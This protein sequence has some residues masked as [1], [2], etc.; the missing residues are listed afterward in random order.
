M[1]AVFNRSITLKSDLCN[2][3]NI[4]VGENVLVNMVVW[5]SSYIKIYFFKYF[6]MRSTLYNKN[7]Y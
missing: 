6:N 2:W 1:I 5:W 4:Y 3:I 7:D